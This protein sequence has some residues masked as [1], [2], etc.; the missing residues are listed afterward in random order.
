MTVWDLLKAELLT[1]LHGL[2]G[3]GVDVTAFFGTLFSAPPGYVF[4]SGSGSSAT[5]KQPSYLIVVF[6]TMVKKVYNLG[7]RDSTGECL[8]TNELFYLSLRLCSALHAH[9]AKHSPRL[10]QFLD[11]VTISGDAWDETR[12]VFRLGV[13]DVCQQ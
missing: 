9:G 8:V 2:V 13:Q 6:T 1:Q 11:S 5:S 3:R 10:Q 12:H 4:R 7:R